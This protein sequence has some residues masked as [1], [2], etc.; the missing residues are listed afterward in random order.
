MK[1]IYK[2][3]S[4]TTTKNEGNTMNIN[5]KSSWIWSLHD[6]KNISLVV[7]SLLTGYFE[8]NHDFRN[9][10]EHIDAIQSVHNVNKTQ[11]KKSIQIASDYINK[12]N[13]N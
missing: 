9:K 1:N 11:A 7:A 8:Y 2:K 6:D 3:T 5:N 12:Q 10:P 4:K 13:N